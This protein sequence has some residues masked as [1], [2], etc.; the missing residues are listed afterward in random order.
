M[1][2][3]FLIATLWAHPF[4]INFYGHDLTI[5]LEGNSINTSYRLEVPSAVLTDRMKQFLI[6]KGE[7]LSK[8][9][10]KVNFID[11]QYTELEAEVDLLID[12]EF[13]PWAKVERKEVVTAEQGQFVT[14]EVEMVAD[15]PKNTATMAIINSNVME[16]RS[17][18]RNQVFVDSH[19]V[20]YDCD[21]VRWKNDSVHSSLHGKWDTSETQREVRLSYTTTPVILA[22]ARKEWRKWIQ[23]GDE[24]IKI[25]EAIR[26]NQG[27]WMDNWKKGMT[28]M[29]T[30][31]IMLL[32]VLSLCFIK[33]PRSSFTFM[34]GCVALL[35][36]FLVGDIPWGSITMPALMGLLLLFLASI[37]R[38]FS[39]WPM[40]LVVLNSIWLK[41]SYLGL[42]L[43]LMLFLF[44]KRGWVIHKSLSS[45]LILVNFLYFATITAIYL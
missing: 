17:I 31:F 15:I 44:S 4:D 21:L 2:F 10:L 16:E 19:T 18:F 7:N 35:V 43:L 38:G 34:V 9:D 13:V 12:D 32:S 22:T 23:G 14:F 5:R 25:D 40:V 11:S 39:Q 41:P 36:V 1:L 8:S 27:S 29:D 30:F 24:E 33:T 26:Q 42:V 20:V 37:V 6:E 45:F 28:S 3:A